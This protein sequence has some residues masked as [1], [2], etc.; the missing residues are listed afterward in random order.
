[1]SGKQRISPVT[2]SNVSVSHTQ[3][4][5]REEVD[6]IFSEHGEE[7]SGNDIKKLKYI[8]QVVQ[9]MAR[10]AQVFVPARICTKDWK[11][12]DSN[13]V[14]PRGMK[15]ILSLGKALLHQISN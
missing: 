11:I 14:I 3:E 2:M 12:P 15:V 10:L 6:Q 13:V 7:L 9:E 5:A 1:M 8:D 4:K